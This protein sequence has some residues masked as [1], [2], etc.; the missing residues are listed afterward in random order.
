M[1]TIGMIG[2]AGCGTVALVLTFIIYQLQSSLKNRIV[3]N[4]LR[5]QL[6][7]ATDYQSRIQDVI[8]DASKKRNRPQFEHLTVQIK[9]WVDD[10]EAL[11]RQVDSFKQDKLIKRD[12]TRLPNSIKS[13]ERKI[14]Q[15][16]DQA[17]QDKLTKTLTGQQAQLDKLKTLQNKMKEAELEIEQTLA[18]LG[19]IYSQLVTGESSKQVHD[20]SHL[21]AEVDEQVQALDD[22][23]EAVD[24]VYQS[25]T[26]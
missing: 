25:R 10:I 2:V 6:K 3:N 1:Q 20:Y 17:I 7:Q 21:T 14:Q 5:K 16:N 26:Y 19:T 22:Y 4:Q 8:R 11:V 15:E 24:E 23:L 13:I 18:S 12:I 9:A